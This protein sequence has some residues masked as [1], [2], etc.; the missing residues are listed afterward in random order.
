M[1][2]VSAAFF[3]TGVLFLGAG[4]IWGMW[5]GSHEDFTLATAHA[6]LN[7]LGWV[8]AALYG[9]FYALTRETMS[10]R[11]AWTNY[12]LSTTGV[13]VMI[14]SLVMLLLSN[15]TAKWSPFVAAGSG[16]VFLGLVVF[17]ASVLRELIRRR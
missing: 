11:L 7:L 15:D 12:A 14:P 5:M 4:M 16:I 2:R 13:I 10:L 9:T 17:A 8:T 1:P 6:H 3:L